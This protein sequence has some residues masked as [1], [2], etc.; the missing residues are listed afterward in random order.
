MEKSHDIMVGEA[1]E[2][3]IQEF[4]VSGNMF[5]EFLLRTSVGDIAPAFSS[6]HQLPAG[7]PVLLKHIDLMPAFGCP[8]CGHK[9]GRACANDAYTFTA[10]NDTSGL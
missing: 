6:Y 5:D 1:A 3:G 7:T 9:T 10:Q 2:S 4:S 8:A